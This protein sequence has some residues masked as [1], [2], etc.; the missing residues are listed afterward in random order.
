MLNCPESGSLSGKKYLGNNFRD[1]CCLKL[2]G[3]LN[4]VL[5]GLV[6]RLKT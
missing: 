5:L 4:S 2:N 6:L 1:F 3:I